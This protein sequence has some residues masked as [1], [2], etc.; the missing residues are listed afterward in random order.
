MVRKW[1]NSGHCYRHHY[2]RAVFV[3]VAHEEGQVGWPCEG[4]DT[5]L[6]NGRI[7]V[8]ADEE[9]DAVKGVIFTLGRG[10]PVPFPRVGAVAGCDVVFFD[11][12]GVKPAVLKEA[13]AIDFEYV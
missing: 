3:E 6:K 1:F 8:D 4:V 13:L 12:V 10:V 5:H 7:F 2:L 9:A 11:R